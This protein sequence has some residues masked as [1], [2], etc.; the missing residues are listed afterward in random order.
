MKKADEIKQLKHE[1]GRYQKKV[2]DQ[3]KEINALKKEIEAKD[4]AMSMSEAVVA[5][6]LNRCGYVSDDIAF[7]TDT[8]EIGEAVKAGMRPMIEK[9][10]G[11][12]TISM[13]CGKG[14]E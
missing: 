14:M 4:M 2:G 3:Q 13:W 9:N 6:M 8:A 10:A 7:E 5:M 11:G 1:L 12:N